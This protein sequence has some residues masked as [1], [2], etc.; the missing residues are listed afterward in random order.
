MEKQ[1]NFFF[2][3]TTATKK[4]FN[5]TKRIRAVKGGTSASKTISILIWCIDYAGQQRTIPEIITVASESFPHLSLGAIRDFQN[6][7]KDAHYWDDN[8]W[9]R[10][11]HT[12]TFE[13]GTIIEFMS[14]DTYSKA[15][16][17]RRDVLFLNEC[18]NLPWDIVDQLITRT[19]KI[20]WMDW[21][22]TEEFWFQTEMLPFRDDIEYITLTY[23]DNEALDKTTVKE[24]E[25]H[26]HNTQWWTVYGLGQDGE[27]E[28]RIYTSWEIIEEIPKE[29]RCV[30]KGLDFGYTNDPTALYDIY[31]YNDG[32]IL[33][34]I[35]YQKGL[36]NSEIANKIGKGQPL[37]VADSA[38]PKSIAEIAMHGVNII[39]SKK[40]K[41]SIN[42]GIDAVRSRKISITKRSVNGIKEYRNYC[43]LKDVNGKITNEPTDIMNHAMDA[44]RYAIADLI[45]DAEPED[46]YIQETPYQ[47]PGLGGT[48]SMNNKAPI[49]TV[50]GPSKNR[51][52]FL[53]ERKAAQSEDYQTDTPYETPG[54]AK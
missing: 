10:T 4:I 7:M 22:P 45:P 38:E 6:I 19:R 49:L 31:R 35:L 5:L 15:H 50:L 13:T 32:F 48:E 53:Q 40:G 46:A 14:V 1:N 30:R 18:N 29:A 52:K 47:T 43:Y 37:C 23:K 39:P 24:I 16:G 26:K 34:E 2:K 41:G 17:P 25:S 42:H 21:N 11:T 27:I 9:N 44:I 20:V 8:R 28:S 33:D 51:L 12:Y 54:L 36:L 3:D